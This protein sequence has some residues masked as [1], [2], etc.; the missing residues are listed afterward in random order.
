MYSIHGLS[1]D[2][3]LAEHHVKRF[4]S[5]QPVFFTKE[6]LVPSECVGAIIGVKGETVR[7]I[8]ERS[9]AKIK[10]DPTE[11]EEIG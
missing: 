9:K 3:A 1:D 4:I 10:V 2:V 8:Q 7:S 5:L 6:I 11:D